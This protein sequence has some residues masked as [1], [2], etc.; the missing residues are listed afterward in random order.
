MEQSRMENPETKATF[1]PINKTKIIKAKTAQNT[2]RMS[3]TN[4]TKNWG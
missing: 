2:K 4:L 3:D 1:G